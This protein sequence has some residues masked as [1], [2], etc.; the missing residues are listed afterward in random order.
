LNVNGT[1]TVKCILRLLLGGSDVVL[2]VTTSEEI[3]DMGTFRN[4][5]QTVVNPIFDSISYLKG[6]VIKAEI[7]SVVTELPWLLPFEHKSGS[8]EK[9]GIESSVP[10]ETFFNL[11]ISSWHLRCALADLREAIESPNDTGF[12]TYRAI[13]TIMQSFK[14][15]ADEEPKY[16]WPRFRQALQVSENYL[17]SM[18]KYSQSNRHGVLTLT[19]GTEREILM[20]KARTII[21]RFALYLSIG[22]RILQTSEFPLLD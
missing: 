21:H 11:A 6:M 20:L 14:S 7:T 18:T 3:K 5:I 12:F 8:I 15:S 19:S 10:P 17:K 13:E 22:N 4:Q 1:E 9:A 2:H 16:V